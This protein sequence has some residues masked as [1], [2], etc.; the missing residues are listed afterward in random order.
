MTAYANG[1][2]M[3][4]ELTIGIGKVEEMQEVQGEGLG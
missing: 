1:P 2:E 3:S 4:Q